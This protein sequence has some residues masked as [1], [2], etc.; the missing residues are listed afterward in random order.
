[1]STGDDNPGVA[2]YET[3]P[4]FPSGHSLNSWVILAM[5]AYLVGCRLNSRAGR[6]ATVV[7]CL[8]LAI[9][10]GLRR[11]YLGHHWLTD[12]LVAGALGSA[13]LIVVIAAHRLALTVQ[14]HQ[15]GA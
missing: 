13:W 2:P 12:V 15:I 14:R 10:M 11:V 4:S 1:M 3:S 8:T 5:V 7:A 9:A 6:T